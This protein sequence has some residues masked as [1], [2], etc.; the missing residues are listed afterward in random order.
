MKNH[1]V[2]DELIQKLSTLGYE[3]CVELFNTWREYVEECRECVDFD[4]NDYYEE[5]GSPSISKVAE[6]VEVEF[7]FTQEHKYP[8]DV[9]G[10][11]YSEEEI[12]AYDNMTDVEISNYIDKG[13]SKFL[14][15]YKK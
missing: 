9:I 6:C 15:E 3:R 14:K 13:I 2:V 1:K 8:E 11:D 10:I 4:K 5:D 7:R 12:D